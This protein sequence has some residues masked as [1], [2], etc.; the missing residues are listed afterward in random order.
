MY[1]AALLYG[2]EYLNGSDL[3]SPH[4]ENPAIWADPRHLNPAGGDVFCR[5]SNS[6]L[7]RI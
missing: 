7:M 5:L 2:V 3:I 4:A 1:R 6:Y